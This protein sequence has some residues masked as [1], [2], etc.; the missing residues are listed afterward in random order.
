MWSPDQLSFVFHD[1]AITT[2]TAQ[3]D[4]R[5]NINARH[6][7]NI[8]RSKNK[9]DLHPLNSDISCT[10]ANRS[11]SIWAA[12]GLIFHGCQQSESWP[13]ECFCLCPHSRRGDS[14]VCLPRHMAWVGIWGTHRDRMM[15][16]SR[17]PRKI[18]SSELSVLLSL[19][20]KKK[21]PN[22]KTNHKG[23]ELKKY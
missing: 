9:P 11:L 18:G 4:S 8:Y 17:G 15:Q 13:Q 14:L 1:Y 21:N 20:D 7:L 22:K 10:K 19:K 3:T 23:A 5:S 2:L 12:F 6:T 16:A